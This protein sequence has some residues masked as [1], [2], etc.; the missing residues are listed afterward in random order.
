MSAVK[1]ML[2][3]RVDKIADKL[4]LPWDEVMDV[5][6]EI[7][8]DPYK[9]FV[10][11]IFITDIVGEDIVE[12]A[13]KYDKIMAYLAEMEGKNADVQTGSITEE[14]VLDSKK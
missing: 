12:K 11:Q 1:R 14:P 2:E 8:F 3:K 6:N 9:L 10:K 13:K 4:D 7:I 5:V